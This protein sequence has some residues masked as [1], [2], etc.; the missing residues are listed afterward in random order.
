MRASTELFAAGRSRAVRC[1][2]EGPRSSAGVAALF[3][4]VVAL[5]VSGVGAV[6]E[7]AALPAGGAM[8]ATMADG[9][10]VVQCT[11]SAGGF[12]TCGVKTDGTLACWGQ[13][14]PPGGTFTQVSAGFAHTCGVKTDGT[15][16][17]W[18]AN[19]DGQA[20]PPGGTF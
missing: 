14:T 20:T 5:V 15:L 2:E 4:C 11:I 7:G 18:G 9:S 13:A 19:G 6:A 8:L 1:S 17:C 16:A 12:H 3:C 10:P